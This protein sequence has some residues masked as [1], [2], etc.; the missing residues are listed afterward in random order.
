MTQFSSSSTTTPASPPLDSSSSV[1][2]VPVFHAQ[3][4]PER[5]RTLRFLRVPGLRSLQWPDAAVLSTAAPPV[6]RV[7]LSSRTYPPLQPPASTIT[8]TSP[9]SVPRQPRTTIRHVSLSSAPLPR[10]EIPKS[11]ATGRERNLRLLHN[12]DASRSSRAGSGGVTSETRQIVRGEEQLRPNH[13]QTLR[14]D[15]F[16]RP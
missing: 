6:R 5:R 16:P 7:V 8:R 1:H 2:L 10:I 4:S 3:G 12:E 11:R 14:F 9:N 13:R 15:R